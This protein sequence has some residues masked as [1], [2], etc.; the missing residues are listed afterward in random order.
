L[1]EPPPKRVEHLWEK[2]LLTGLS[3]TNAVLNSTPTDHIYAALRLIRD[4]AG[5]S[6]RGQN[7]DRYERI[8]RLTTYLVKAKKE[9][10]GIFHYE[11]MMDAMIDPR[12]SV[13]GV[14]ALMQD[15]STHGIAPSLTLCESA[16]AALAVHPDYGLRQHILDTMQEYWYKVDDTSRQSIL[17]GQLR[18]EQYEL[19]YTGLLS[20]LDS[21]ARVDIWMY[22]IFIFALGRN[23]FLD[24]MVHLLIRRQHAESSGDVFHNLAYY[25]LDKCSSG[26]HY[27]GT[28]F[29]WNCIVRNDLVK[30]AD[31]MLENILAT[32][33]REG[34]AEL[35]TEVHSIIS[36]RSRVQ[37]HHYE[38][39][40]EAFATGG[41]LEGALRLLCIMERNG[42]HATR[43]NTRPIYQVLLSRPHLIEDAG[44]TLRDMAKDQ[45]VPPGAVSVIVE[46]TASGRGGEAAMALY[47]DFEELTG[48]KPD[49]MTLQDVIIH[50]RSVDAKREL[51]DAYEGVA[52]RSPTDESLRTSW[53]YNQLIPACLETDRMN[54]AYRFARQAVSALETQS[55]QP[56]WLVPLVRRAVADEDGRIWPIVDAFEDDGSEAAKDLRK[57]LQWGKMARKAAGRG[58]SV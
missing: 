16:L 40:V 55:P 10:L 30:P 34:D 27:Q 56:S 25:V 50:C 1:A 3:P 14:R 57:I 4:P 13:R 41:D 48:Q 6:Y 42:T 45:R 51:L 54:L 31:G 8:I 11:C 17:L 18:D 44:E 21:D 15:M 33:A 32:A 46:A 2:R 5:Y 49:T 53:V 26:F 47:Q 19:A 22:D 38:A 7:I 36:S 9:P 39:L 35:A 29:A 23:D 52:S 37:V 20:M 58:L 43:A 28:L 24:E 12:G